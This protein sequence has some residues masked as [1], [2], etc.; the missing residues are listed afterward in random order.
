MASRSI[1]VQG[2]RMCMQCCQES[3]ALGWLKEVKRAIKVSWPGR[4][5]CLI[6]IH[7]RPSS[8]IRGSHIP[9]HCRWMSWQGWRLRRSDGNSWYIVH[10]GATGC[11]CLCPPPGTCFWEVYPPRCA[12]NTPHCLN[13]NLRQLAPGSLGL[14]WF[15]V[16]GWG[17]WSLSALRSASGWSG[18]GWRPL[19]SGLSKLFRASSAFALLWV[20]EMAR[21]ENTYIVKKTINF[22]EYFIAGCGSVMSS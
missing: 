21:S 7:W 12:R 15:S 11:R 17:W 22:C 9:Q 8:S 10:I 3:S 14:G 6:G 16:A 2:Y 4:G 13:S 1:I 19:A 20:V 18:H 5:I